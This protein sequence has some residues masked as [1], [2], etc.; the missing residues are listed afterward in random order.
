MGKILG[1]KFPIIPWKKIK[2]IIMLFPFSV[3]IIIKYSNDV[4]LGQK[5]MWVGVLS[6]LKL[7]HR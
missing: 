6:V 7:G 2:L 1:S 4:C 5:T 3:W